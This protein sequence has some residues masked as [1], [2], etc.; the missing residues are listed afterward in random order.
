MVNKIFLFRNRI[1]FRKF[2]FFIRLPFRLFVWTSHKF[3]GS[4]YNDF[5]FEN[6]LRFTTQRELT[7]MNT[8]KVCGYEST[9][10]AV[11]GKSEHVNN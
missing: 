9:R 5:F 6:V 7:F 8:K 10:F 4:I 1:I 2:M 3:A 11:V